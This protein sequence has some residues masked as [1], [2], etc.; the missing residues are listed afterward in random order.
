MAPPRFSIGIDLGTTNSA[1][2]FVPLTRDAASEVFMVPQWGS[3]STLVEHPTLPSFL[4]LPAEGG[5]NRLPGQASGAREWVIGLLARQKAHEL[6]GRVAHSAK[7]WLC[8][9]AADREAPF[10]P[11]GSEDVPPAEKISPVRASALILAYLRSAWNERFAAAGPECRFDAQEIT[12]TVPASFDAAAQRLTLTAAEQAGYPD[13]VRL[14]EEPQAAFYN[15]LERH[16]PAKDL[17]SV[18]SLPT[19]EPAHV[20]VVDVGGGTSDFSLFEVHPGAVGRPRIKRLSVGEHILLGGDNIDLALAHLVEPRLVGSEGKLA[21]ASWDDLVAR[22]RDIKEK[23]LSDRGPAD[24]EFPISLPG[25]GA[26][27]VAAARSARI[28]RTDIDGVLLD[29][30][31]PPCDGDARVRRTQAALKEWGLPYAADSAITRHLA[32]FLQGRARVDA[33]LFNGGALYPERVREQLCQEIGKWCQSVPPPALVNPHPDLAVAC[34]AAHFGRLVHC[35]GERIEAGAARAVFIETHQTSAKGPGPSSPSLVC[36]LPRGAPPEE[37]F[38]ITDLSLRLRVNRRVRFQTYS[39]PR[40]GR[41]K[42]GDV[43][44]WSE[45]DLQALPPLQ[46]VVKLDAAEREDGRTLPVTLTAKLSEL[47][48]LQVACHSADPD[49]R[50]SWPLDFDLRAHQQDAGPASSSPG[51]P[52][53]TATANAAPAAVDEARKRL[54]SVFSPP[55]DARNKLTAARV[56][57]GLE[58]ILGLAKGEWNWVLVRTL[59]SSLAAASPRLSVDHEET[60]LILAGFLL[61]PGFGADGDEGRIDDLWHTRENGSIFP[62]KRIRLQE[63]ILWRRVAGGLSRGRQQAVIAG[64]LDKLRGPKDPPPELILLA[65]SLERLEPE[66]KAELIERFVS[67]AAEL[68]HRGGHAAP[69]LAALGL[70]L[71]RAP[72]Y[73]G[74]ETVVS[75]KLVDLA[76]DTL[77]RLD[78]APAEAAE[79]HALFLKAARVVDNRSLD[80]APKLRGRIADKLEK[81]GVPPLKTAK[82]RAFMPVTASERPGLFAERLPPGLILGQP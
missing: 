45:T 10:L 51:A 39:S 69:Y 48:L 77:F 58:K 8:H 67:A 40:H 41:C 78:W 31:F 27:L 37:S 43:I 4:Y 54:L 59:W 42:A 81:M 20:L 36:I 68:A 34:G 44:P 74:P 56:T 17:W 3:I 70:L 23:A 57:Q 15:W 63:Y 9:H 47:G 12:I 28:T 14:L 71:T 49:I 76:Y 38:Q 46:T 32:A 33:V 80:V 25:R 13:T 29:G 22:C 72:L 52:R 64:E 53:V 26:S 7:S 24:E 21:A 82:L 50:R 61:R 66:I 73:A 16:D 1:M 62:G 19:G 11:W 6:P 79:L 30:F 2:A 55:A 35:Q 5:A 18:L 60:W 65:G 75:P